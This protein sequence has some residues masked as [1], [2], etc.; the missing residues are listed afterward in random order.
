MPV[1]PLAGTISGEAVTSE[2]ADGTSVGVSVAGWPTAGVAT[3]PTD[4]GGVSDTPAVEPAAPDLVNPPIL[5]VPHAT[6]TTAMATRSGRRRP[7]IQEDR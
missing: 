2:E 1:Q 3:P 6:A 7:G 5:G 4:A